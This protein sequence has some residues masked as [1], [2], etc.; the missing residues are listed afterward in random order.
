MTS[1][2]ISMGVAHSQSLTSLLFSVA[3]IIFWVACLPLLFLKPELCAFIYLFISRSFKLCFY[4][5]YRIPAI[6]SAV[7]V[8]VA[9]LAVF[10]WAIAK[11]GNGGPLFSNPECVHAI[12]FVWR[13]LTPFS[14]S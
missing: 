12:V 13:L 6:V 7:I 1:V 5:R 4:Y 9:A 2:I 11:Q 3:F 8:L 14:V 10:I